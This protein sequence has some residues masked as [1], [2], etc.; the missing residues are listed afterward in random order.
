[1][2]RWISIG[3]SAWIIGL[4]LLPARYAL[5]QVSTANVAGLVEDSTGARIPDANVKLINNL[6]GAEN[7]SKTNHVGIFLL[8]DVIPLDLQ[9][10]S[11]RND[12]RK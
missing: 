4:I 8:P 10:I 12:V 6:T 7:D 2:P 5:A 3:I 9:G 11:S 1:M